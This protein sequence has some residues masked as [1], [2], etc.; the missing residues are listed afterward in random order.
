MASLKDSLI[1]LLQNHPEP[2]KLSN[3]RLTKL[4]YLADWRSSIKREKQLTDTKW[5]FNHYGPYAE[6]VL[7]L[8]MDD[9]CFEVIEGKNMFGGP[10]N[11]I[12][13]VAASPQISLSEDEKEI[14]DHVIE[15]TSPY[16]YNEFIRLVYSTYPVRASDRYDYLNLP[17][18]AK[19]Y[20]EEKEAI[21]LGNN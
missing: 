16:E 12:R 6:A 18:L 10:K 3:S 1:Y 2:D 13:L 15:H 8:A 17:K 20:K 11:T 4:V 5:R 21:G 9:P 7:N 14:L 19:E